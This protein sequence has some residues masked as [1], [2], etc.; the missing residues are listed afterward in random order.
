MEISRKTDYALRMLATLVR[1]P[2]S[3][4]SVRAA[5][6][7]NNV[8]YSFARSIQ[9]D[10]ALAGLVESTRGA[11]GGMRL[12]VD[13]KE[14]SLLTLVEAVQGPVYIATCDYAGEGGAPCPFMAECHFNPV[15]CNAELMLRDYFNSVTLHDVVVDNKMPQFRGTFDLVAARRAHAA[16]PAGEKAA[17]P[18]PVG[19]DPEAAAS[20]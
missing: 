17:A 19:Q 9:H 10:L 8:P 1:N 5:A 12:A 3:V 16:A 18:G 13:P 4:V 20:A 15:W 14:T 11:A 2:G 6:A 7:E